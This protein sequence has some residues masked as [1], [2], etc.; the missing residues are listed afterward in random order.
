MRPSRAKRRAQRNGGARRREQ[1]G[2]G[3]QPRGP[4]RRPVVAVRELKG[5][6]RRA[7]NRPTGSKGPCSSGRRTSSRVSARGRRLRGAWGEEEGAR[8]RDDLS[9]QTHEHVA[10]KAERSASEPPPSKLTSQKTAA[11]NADKLSD[12]TAPSRCIPALQDRDFSE[13]AGRAK[14]SSFQLRHLLG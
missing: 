4:T 9:R 14:S 11:P 5:A 10:Q 12:S 6:G 13:G 1:R 7:V 2:V 8:A 3:R